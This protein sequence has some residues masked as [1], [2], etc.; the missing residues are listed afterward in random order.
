V[1]ISLALT[2]IHRI[3]SPNTHYP[4]PLPHLQTSPARA[5]LLHVRVQVRISLAQPTEAG[6]KR[7]LRVCG[8]RAD[9]AAALT[10]LRAVGVC[11]HLP[12]SP[13]QHSGHAVSTAP[14]PPKAFGVF[15]AA[16]RGSPPTAAA[17]PPPA[18]PTPA[19]PTPT[20]PARPVGSAGSVT[21]AFS[22]LQRTTSTAAAASRA[23]K[24]SS[25]GKASKS[26]GVRGRVKW[27]PAEEAALRRGFGALGAKWKEILSRG[28]FHERRTSVDLKDK[29]RNLRLVK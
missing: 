17:A 3:P 20:P 23:A 8:A 2:L 24:P 26:A 16:A 6:G 29:A 18:A 28:G 10:A 4:H 1:S 12:P 19:A 22:A 27:S 11:V 13:A 14:P 21:H 9:V 5:S 15:A 7:E 25:K